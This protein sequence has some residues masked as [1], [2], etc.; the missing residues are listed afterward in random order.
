MRAFRQ[1]GS[2]N[3]RGV[4]G[5][6]RQFSRFEI[7]PED[8]SAPCPSVPSS[9]SPVSF[10]Y[11]FSR[12]KWRAYPGSGD[13]IFSWLSKTKRS[14]LFSPNW[15]PKKRPLESVDAGM[16]STCARY[17]WDVCS[18]RFPKRKTAVGVGFFSAFRAGVTK[19]CGSACASAL[20]SS[21]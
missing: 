12:D 13:G 8:Q 3:L 18:S 21:D 6:L 5:V 14:G 16:R 15:R 7:S 11:S 10:H 17:L 1:N 20:D 2:G 19:A 4:A 9:S